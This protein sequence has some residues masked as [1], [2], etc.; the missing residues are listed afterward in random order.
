M[1]VEAVKKTCAGLPAG[2]KKNTG[3]LQK[4]TIELNN[5][6]TALLYITSCQQRRGKVFWHV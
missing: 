5:E 4:S 1:Q 6:N 2:H 3:Y